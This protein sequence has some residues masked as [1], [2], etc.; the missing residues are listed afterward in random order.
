M[1]KVGHGSVDQK[2]E[3]SMEVMEKKELQVRQIILVHELKLFHGLIQ[4]ITFICLEVKVMHLQASAVIISLL[5]LILGC[6][7]DLWKFD[8]ES[9]TWISGEN[10]AN[11]KAVYGE[12]GV[13]NEANI[14]GSRNGASAWIDSFDNVYLFGG[15]GYVAS[16]A[17][18]SFFPEFNIVGKLSDLWKF[19]GTIWTWIAG[20]KTKGRSGSYGQKGVPHQDNVPSS[21]Y[22]SV[23]WTDPFNNFYLFGGTG[24]TFVKN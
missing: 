13:P 8:G 2:Q 1:V 10:T 15:Y 3:I 18:G 20:P 6:L 12:L 4:R 16:G 23:S 9:W 24:I 19:N 22:Y 17:T 21:R 14:P 7:N 11:K 5:F